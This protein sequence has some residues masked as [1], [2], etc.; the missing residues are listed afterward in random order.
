MVRCN[1]DGDN[2]CGSVQVYRNNDL[3][4]D[5]WRQGLFF[6]L[7]MRENNTMLGV[8]GVYF[9]FFSRPHSDPSYFNPLR[10]EG[11]VPA[12]YLNFGWIVLDISVLP[13]GC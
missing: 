11:L 12:H 1:K 2:F 9:F 4:F 6:F 8:W 13:A 7:A 10:S 3:E 5:V